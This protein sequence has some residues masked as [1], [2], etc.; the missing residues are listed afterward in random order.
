MLA[1]FNQRLDNLG[2]LVVSYE[3]VLMELFVIHI[4]NNDV[5]FYL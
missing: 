5:Y 2:G 4:I 1:L 3:N